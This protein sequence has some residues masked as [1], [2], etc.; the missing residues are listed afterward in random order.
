M[1]EHKHTVYA[2]CDAG[3]LPLDVHAWTKNS[4]DKQ[5]RV[6]LANAD[7]NDMI[8]D[9]LLDAPKWLPIAAEAL[10]ISANI[11]DYVLIPVPIMPADLPNRNGVA[12]PFSEL[13]AWN[14]EAGMVAYKTWVGKPTFV[15]H[16]NK[17][18]AEAK[19]IIFDSVMR[20]V[21][22]V[23]GELWKVVNLLGF[24]RNRDAILANAILTRQLTTYSMGAYVN[25]YTCSICKSSVE[26]RC[27]HVQVGTPNWRMFDSPTGKQLAFLNSK[28]VMGFETSSVKIPA[29][30][31]AD[32]PFTF[33]MSAL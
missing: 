25:D 14:T 19:G 33:N 16:N 4:L 7:V 8:R 31:S 9:V 10:N 18:P 21:N 26:R 30:T 23:Q 13:T 5:T 28:G 1:S 2:D 11:K 20:K 29:Y 15:E 27:D 17:N 6:S 32:N 3:A 24:D 22:G 12:F